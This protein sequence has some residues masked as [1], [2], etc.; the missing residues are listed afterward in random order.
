M[1][2]NIYDNLLQFKGTWRDYQD[3][4][5]TNSP[6][7]RAD[8][9]LRIGAAPGSGKQ[10]LGIELIRRLGEPCLVLSPS[11]T[12]RQQWLERITD[13]FLTDGCSPETI[14]SNDLKN[15][16]MI[17]AVTYQALY[18]AVK[19]YEGSLEDQEESGE[20]SAGDPET[21]ETVDFRDFDLFQSVKEAVVRKVVLDKGV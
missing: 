15:M 18:S 19:H 3:R 12:I 14:L 11:I 9:K 5:L 10:T 16:K 1:M 2:G 4:V 8:R 7:Y 6:K 17:T 21:A 13:G 20:E